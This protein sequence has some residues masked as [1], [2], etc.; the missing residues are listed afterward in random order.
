MERRLFKRR[1]WPVL[2]AAVLAAAVW[3]ALSRSGPGGARAVVERNG[4]VVLSREL[5]GLS[6][7]EFAEIEGENGVRLTVEFSREGA[8]VIETNCPGKTCQRTGLLT[9]AGES[10]VCLPGRVVLRLEGPGT[11]TDAETY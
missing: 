9:R 6:E 8:R 10:A 3:L 7:P 4:S 5:E 1:D 11:E 2:L